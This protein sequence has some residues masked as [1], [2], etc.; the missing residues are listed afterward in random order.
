MTNSEQFLPI[1]EKLG[2]KAIS[3]TR[4]ESISAARLLPGGKK[5][6]NPAPVRQDP[7]FLSVKVHPSW[8]S[9]VP[10]GLSYCEDALLFGP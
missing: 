6:A 7:S 5:R 2:Q 10:R 1:G 3:A 9:Q 8:V 4:A